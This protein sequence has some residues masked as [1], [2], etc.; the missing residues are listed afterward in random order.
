MKGKVN[1]LLEMIVEET[2]IIII[3]L[4]LVDVLVSVL[5]KTTIVFFTTF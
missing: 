5:T 1:F 3:L 4:P 2:I